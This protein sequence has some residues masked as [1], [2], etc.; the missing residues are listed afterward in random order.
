MLQIPVLL[1]YDPVRSSHPCL[2][3]V[4]GTL[5]SLEVSSL[6][7]LV[8]GSN[9]KAEKMP[10]SEGFF[11]EGGGKRLR[12]SRCGKQAR[13]NETS[14]LAAGSEGALSSGL[15]GDSPNS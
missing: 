15:L 8:E 12:K 9:Y 4:D 5:H 2:C 10:H 7:S 1:K 3:F 13:L 11:M 6:V 14:V